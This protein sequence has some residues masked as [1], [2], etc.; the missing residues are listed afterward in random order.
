ML[1]HSRRKFRLL[2][3]EHRVSS[4]FCL[5]FLAFALE[6]LFKHF[7]LGCADLGWD[8]SLEGW[9]CK[10]VGKVVIGVGFLF[11]FV[12]KIELKWVLH[13]T[14]SFYAF[15]LYFCFSLFV[16]FKDLA[17]SQRGYLWRYRFR[18]EPVL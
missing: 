3:A 11:F 4:H 12:A 6:L 7:F 2:E 17:V 5:S 1:L 18:F 9:S 10:F 8:S 14:C 16:F 13:G 15:T